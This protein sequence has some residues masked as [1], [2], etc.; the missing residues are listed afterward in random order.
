MHHA[1]RN[2]KGL[3]P[4]TSIHGDTRELGTRLASLAVGA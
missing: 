4:V 1:K 3:V 2:R